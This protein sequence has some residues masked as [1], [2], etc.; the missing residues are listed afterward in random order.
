MT[1]RYTRQFK[2][3]DSGPDVEGVGRALTRSHVR[4]VT[5]FLA[6]VV[7]PKRMRRKWGPRKQHDLRLF[8]KAKGLKPDDLYTKQAHAALTP[9]FDATARKLMATDEPKPQPLI[10]PRQ[11]F[12]SLS[13]S[14]WDAYSDG[15][16]LGLS[17]EGTF[18]P[19]SRLPSGAPSDHAVYPAY[20]FDLGVPSGRQDLGWRFFNEMKSRPGINYVIYQTK[21]WSRASGLHA[22]TYG[23]HESHVHT[24]GV[25]GLVNRIR[26]VLGR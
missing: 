1:V 24:S 20:A 8:K 26:D 22:Y 2:P 4:G 25:R 11:G 10:E 18:N 6:F 23:G 9:F 13:R 15:R 12:A 3:G 19:H 5:S 17:D 16:R 7:F 14:L 21:I